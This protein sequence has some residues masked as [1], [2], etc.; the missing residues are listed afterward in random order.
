MESYSWS[1]SRGVEVM[2]L[3]QEPYLTPQN[4]RDRLSN[5]RP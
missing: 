1:I 2:P 4:N 3:A 5:V